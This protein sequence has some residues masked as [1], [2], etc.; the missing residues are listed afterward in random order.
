MVEVGRLRDEPLA[1][2]G[3]VQKQRLAKRCALRAH[4]IG[5]LGLS[6][7]AEEGLRMVSAGRL[8][9]NTE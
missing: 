6:L 4:G 5:R 2:V 7:R 9:V 3:I 8:Q 1:M